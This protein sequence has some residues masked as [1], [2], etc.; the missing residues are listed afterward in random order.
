M[1]TFIRKNGG[2]EAFQ[3]WRKSNKELAAMAGELDVRNFKK[4]ISDAETT[5]EN[6]ATLLFSKKPS[7]VKRLV[8]NISPEGRRKAQSAILHRAIEKA[9]GIDNISPDR[10]AN[11]V[12]RL[13]NSVGIVFEGSELASL[14]GLERLLQSTKQ[15]S[16]ASVAPPT[17]V[18]NTPIVGGFAAGSWLGAGA[19]PWAAAAGGLARLYESAPV[20]NM[21]VA[22]RRTQPGSK[23]ESNLLE[24]IG[25]VAASQTNIQSENVARAANSNV[26]V[27]L[28]A[29]EGQEN[30]REQ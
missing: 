15:A 27:P 18:Q 25:K 4:V 16:V 17:G 12:G 22:L 11:E 7:D 3:T 19:I 21:L 10:F 30:Q 28:A 14:K 24:K 9:G 5:P 8:A 2:E 1:A 23:A 6:V 29:D 26:P 20:R 13:G